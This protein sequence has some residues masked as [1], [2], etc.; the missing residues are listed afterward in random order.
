MERP[1]PRLDTKDETFG[2]R[3]L[4]F[5]IDG[6]I[7]GVVGAVLIGAMASI[8]PMLT[9]MIGTVFGLAAILYFIYFEGA[10]GQT[11]GKRA[12]GIVVVKT[13]G[14]DTDMAASA[15]R[16][17][18][19]IIDTLPTLYILGIL[20]I[21]VTEDNQRLGDIVGNTVVVRTRS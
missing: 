13:D 7:L 19:R 20:L 12:M 3:I 5:L 4:A 18:L 16:N 17:L 15:I 10:Y 6:L 1:T 14:G 8:D 21:L 9:S 11:L 2:A